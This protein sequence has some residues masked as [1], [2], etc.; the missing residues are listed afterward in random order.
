MPDTKKGKRTMAG[1]NE[2]SR[3][4]ENTGG[5]K[6]NVLH[7]VYLSII[8]AILTI[9]FWTLSMNTSDEALR[10]FSFASSI[11]SIV[12]AVVSIAYSLV[13]GKN[14][15]ASL[16]S[17]SKTSDDIRTVGNNIQRIGDKFSKV[18]TDI[19]GVAA[20]IENVNQQLSGEIEKIS[21][22]ESN[23]SSILTSNENLSERV[24]ALLDEMRKTH[25]DVKGINEIL[26]KTKEST[27]TGKKGTKKNPLETFDRSNYTIAARLMLYACSLTQKEGNTKAFP[28]SII[29]NEDW[30]LY[31]YGY[32]YSLNGLLGSNIFAV[33]VT[34]ER[35]LTVKKFDVEYF[36]GLNKEDL[37]NDVE[38]KDFMEENITK[39]EGYFEEHKETAEEQ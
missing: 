7:L 35:M 26:G 28:L 23:V 10:L 31:F 12:L 33:D 38:R 5:K 19:Q 39:I 16:G 9:L 1:N 2:N 8:F 36:K 14:V 17:I 27:T 30:N 4:T 15:D 11:T 24:S 37:L 6:V 22:L 21:G 34:E 18:S 20:G 29:L 25:A 3:T 13:S 32:A